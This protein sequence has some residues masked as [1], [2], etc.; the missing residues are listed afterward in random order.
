MG[1]G[2]LLGGD[3]NS[4]AFAVSGDGRVVVGSSLSTSGEEAFRWENGVISGLGDLPGGAIRTPTAG[5]PPTVMR[6]DPP[7]TLRVCGDVGP[8]YRC[9]VFSKVEMSAFSADSIFSTAEA[10]GLG[11]KPGRLRD[12]RL[13]HCGGARSG[14]PRR[15]ANLRG[16]RA[17]RWRAPIPG[18]H[19]S[20]DRPCP[21]GAP[22]VLPF[23]AVAAPTQRARAVCPTCPAATRAL[24]FRFQATPPADE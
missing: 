11:S 14:P 23:A 4:A 20:R 2:D 12:S 17:G 6:G 16:P 10:P 7:G 24:L 19:R 15:P 18:Q 8:K 13:A 9:P 21:R 3:F 5:S 22:C 1:L